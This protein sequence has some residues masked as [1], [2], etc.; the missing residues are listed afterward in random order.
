MGGCVSLVFWKVFRGPL[1]PVAELTGYSKEQGLLG[2]SSFF[3]ARGRVPCPW[4]G[5]WV[6]LAMVTYVFLTPWQG[7]P[8]VSF[9]GG[10]ECLVISTRRGHPRISCSYSIWCRL[11]HGARD[12]FWKHGEAQEKPS[13]CLFVPFSPPPP[14]TGN[15][16]SAHF[17]RQSW[18]VG[19]PVSWCLRNAFL[20]KMKPV[21]VLTRCG[22]LSSVLWGQNDFCHS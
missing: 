15:N 11:F 14:Q 20:S 6:A 16:E 18:V 3:T 22:P 12:Y 17:I 21:L 1:S 2:I 13:R 10:S 7:V 5:D 4:P 8:W 19:G 9:G